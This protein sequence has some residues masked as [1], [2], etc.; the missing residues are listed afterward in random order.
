MRVRQILLFS[1]AAAADANAGASGVFGCLHI[2]VTIANKKRAAGTDACESAS[3]KNHVRSGFAA[4]T[5]FIRAMWTVKGGLNTSAVFLHPP[6]DPFMH[7]PEIAPV[8]KA[9]IDPR[10]VADQYDGDIFAMEV[11]ERFEGILVKA[12]FFRALY[13]IRPVNIQNAVAVHEEETAVFRL[14]AVEP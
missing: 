10:L 11:F 12:N 6:S 9:P 2:G 1:A 13:E 3:G 5:F 7:S 8:D 4:P 14:G